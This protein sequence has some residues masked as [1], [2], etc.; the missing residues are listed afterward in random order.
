MS[1]PNHQPSHTQERMQWDTLPP[2]FADPVHDSQSVFRILLDALARPARLFRIE[3]A[4]D[5]GTTATPVAALAALYALCDFATPVWLASPNQALSSALRFHSGAPLAEQPADA[6]FAWIDDAAAM[7]ALSSFA[8]GDAESPE[9]S[10]TLLIRVSSLSGGPEL[11]CSG[12]G[13]ETTQT[14]A[15]LGLPS[16]F[17]QARAELAGL[18]PCGV[19]LYLICDDTLAGVP[20]TTRVEEA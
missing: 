5:T 17:W 6:T 16:G 13:I 10:A 9:F 2:G 15:P 3:T 11:K 4:L 8:L 12:P 19:D 18:F 1:I 14:M 20:R 7:P